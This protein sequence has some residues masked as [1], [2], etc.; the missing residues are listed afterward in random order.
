MARCALVALWAVAGAGCV[1]TTQSSAAPTAVLLVSNALDGTISRIDPIDGRVIGAPLPGG[2]APAQ[3][4]VGASGE[5]LVQSA[6]AKRGAGLTYV[7]RGFDRWRARPVSLG[8][9]AR[10]PLLAGGGRYAVVAYGAGEPPAGQ[11]PTRC[12]IALFDLARGRLIATHD[13]CSGRDTIVALAAGSKAGD[14]QGH[15]IA[16]VALWR[17]PGSAAECNGAT[18]SRVVALRPDTGAPL[19]TAPSADGDL[20]ETIPTGRRP[21]GIVSTA[22]PL[23]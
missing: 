6:S 16:Y 11:A 13:V 1:R 20:V 9:S 17:R 3:V 8:P 18:G 12:R 23:H 15:P 14:G 2:E 10:T 4:A 22:A 5:M 19:A 7:T 21:I